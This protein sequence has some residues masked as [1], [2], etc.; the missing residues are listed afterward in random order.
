MGN[1]GFFFLGT[2]SGREEIDTY[3]HI[4]RGHFEHIRPY[5]ILNERFKFEFELVITTWAQRHMNQSIL[6]KSEI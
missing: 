2:P 4:L 3:K 1:H 6:K 5:L